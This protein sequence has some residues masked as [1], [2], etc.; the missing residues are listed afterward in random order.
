MHR[1]VYACHAMLGASTGILLCRY[2]SINALPTMF[3][4]DQPYDPH[5]D[6]PPA[7]NREDFSGLT[8]EHG[9]EPQSILDR[10]ASFLP[11]DTLAEFMD[12]LAM[13][14]I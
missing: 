6:L 2:P 9:F 4:P 14:R 1:L 8:Y 11:A 12:D 5:N 10:L 13:G 7:D 3:T